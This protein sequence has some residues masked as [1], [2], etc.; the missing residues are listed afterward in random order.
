M[1][2]RPSLTSTFCM[3]TFIVKGAR[4]GLSLFEKRKLTGGTITIASPQKVAA[5]C[6]FFL[7][8]GNCPRI[9]L[10]QWRPFM[11]KT[12]SLAS[13]RVKG[14]TV[15]LSTRENRKFT[16]EKITIASPQKVLL[17]VSEIVP[18]CG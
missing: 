15:R 10:V 11:T 7:C 5:T 17:C 1:Q 9:W 18:G 12:F 16:G 14:A 4:V 6:S 3:A 2:W 13:F 8:V